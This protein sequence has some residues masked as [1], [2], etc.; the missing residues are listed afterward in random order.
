LHA[1]EEAAADR[2]ELL[3]RALE[4]IFRSRPT[5]SGV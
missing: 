5:L 1:S 2:L 3:H 4:A